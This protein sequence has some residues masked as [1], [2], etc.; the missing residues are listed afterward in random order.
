MK[1]KQTEN[2]TKTAKDKGEG[3]RA[4]TTTNGEPDSKESTPAAPSQRGTVLE[5]LSERVVHPTRIQFRGFPE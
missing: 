2:N 3:K 5:T 1:N 4:K